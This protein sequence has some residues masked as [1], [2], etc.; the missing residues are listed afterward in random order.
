MIF[1][2][3]TFLFLEKQME[4]WHVTEDLHFLK[5]WGVG[6]ILLPFVLV[7]LVVDLPQLSLAKNKARVLG[8]EDGAGEQDGHPVEAQQVVLVEG[9]IV[10]QPQLEDLCPFGHA[11]RQSDHD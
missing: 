2:A 5:S 4:D 7:E 9:Q 3:E 10:G 8:D 6:G 11:V 1:A